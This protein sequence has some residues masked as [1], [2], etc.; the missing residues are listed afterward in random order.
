[1]HERFAHGWWVRV[2]AAAVRVSRGLGFALADGHF[3]TASPRV[4]ALAPSV[5]AIVGLAAG[6][7]TLG[8]DRAFTEALWV[9]IV[10]A[11]AG[12]VAG[13]LGAAFVGGFAIGDFVLGQRAWTHRTFGGGILDDGLVA[14]LLRVRLPLLIGYALLAVLAVW[15]PR[16]ARALL[17]DIPRVGRLPRQAAFG[18]AALANVV[19]VGIGVRLWAEASAVLIRPL[20]TWQG[21]QPTS[22]AVTPLQEHGDLLV[23]LAIV[24]TIAR[25]A[26]LWWASDTSERADRVARTERD[27]A[28]GPGATP[29]LERPGPLVS[30]VVAA[31]ATTLL[32]AGVLE[33]WWIAGVMFAVF[34]ALRLL[35]A[36]VLPLRLEPWR[37]VV[38]NVPVLLRLAVALLVVD[39]IRR[40]FVDEFAPTFTQLALYLTGAVVVLFLLLPG[41]P[42][43]PRPSTADAGRGPA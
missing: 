42:A 30:S 17:S 29:W 9:M 27:L 4:A 43:A 33:R 34:L 18:I 16:I 39:Q 35:R 22:A 14:G 1:M 26:M 2:P 37:R 25:F 24:A 19:I 32:L 28:R 38:V 7:T 21:G 40:A 13:G 15:L 12:H 20:F 36:D 23:G 5:L 41:A 11:L 10:A 31:A 6:A 3:L 8:Y